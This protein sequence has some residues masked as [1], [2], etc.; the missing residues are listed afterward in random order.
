MRLWLEFGI[1]SLFCLQVYILYP[2]AVELA[3]VMEVHDMVPT[4]LALES[5]LTVRSPYSEDSA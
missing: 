3:G 2:E 5:V 1:K 4:W